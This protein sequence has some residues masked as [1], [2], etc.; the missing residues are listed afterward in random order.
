MNIVSLSCTSCGAPL[1]VSPESEQL[2]CPYCNAVLIIERSEGQV[3]FKLGEQVSRSIEHSSDTTQTELK[4]LQLIQEVSMLQMQLSTL[5]AEIRSLQ[6]Q[7]PNKQINQQLSDLRSQERSLIARIKSIQ[8]SLSPATGVSYPAQ[9]IQAYRPE[10]RE[11]DYLS[12]NPKNWVVTYLL[13]LFLGFFGLH[14]F[15]T[16]HILLGILQAISFGGFA[17]WWFVDLFFIAFRK[18]KDSKG[19][20]LNGP[21]PGIGRYIAIGVSILWLVYFMSVVASS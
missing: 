4:R 16:G 9:E 12:S 21:K 15:Y 7:A 14:R 10:D 1:N 8:N 6:R 19:S 2:R 11:N 13:C 18:F 20:L 17:I 3:A 5:E